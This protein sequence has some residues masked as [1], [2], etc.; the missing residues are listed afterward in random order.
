MMNKFL[1]QKYAILSIFCLLG[2]T[3]QVHEALGSPSK[4]KI[5]RLQ[6]AE[7]AVGK[8]VPSDNAHKL[9]QAR[10]GYCF[11]KRPRDGGMGRVP[12]TWCYFNPA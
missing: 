11:C 10:G 5:S 3:F 2:F 12:Y 4:V 7:K 8:V 1:Y 9:R 6:F